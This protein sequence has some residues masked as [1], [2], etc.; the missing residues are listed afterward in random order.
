M[1]DSSGHASALR[2]PAEGSTRLPYWLYTDASIYALEQERIFGGRHWNYV[3]LEC[4]IPATGDYKRTF[5]GDSSV[6]VVRGRDGS[7]N[8]LVNRCSHRGAQFCQTTLGHTSTFICPYH[9]WSFAL[10]GTCI[11]VPFRRGLRG[12]GGYPESFEPAD[13]SLPTLA[14]A[15]RGGVIFA[16]FAHDMPSL[17]SYIGETMLPLFDREFD[18]RALEVI[19]YSRQRIPGNW[20]LIVENLIDP[21]HTSL[22][23]TFFATFGLFRPDQPSSTATDA[24]GMHSA[25]ITVRGEQVL[26]ESTREMKNFRADLK[27]ADPRLLDTVREYAG[28]PTAVMSVIWPNVILQQQSNTLATRQIVPRGPGE[29][30]LHW[31]F[32]GYADDPEDLRRR[33]VMQANLMGPGGYISMEDGEIIER[34]QTGFEKHAGAAAVVELG[35]D[36]GNSDHMVSEGLIRAMYGPYRTV[37]GL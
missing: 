8:A 6:V 10:D 16:S 31:T 11:G 20:K 19:G 29:F 26:D 5:V 35:D 12:K 24:T 18:G 23:H 14:V 33:R 2:W 32:F 9:Q 22:L 17:E 34:Q 3:G 21:Y 37:M 4:E 15:T 27:L 36:L 7:I 28:T 13:H 1:S 25:Q 30:D